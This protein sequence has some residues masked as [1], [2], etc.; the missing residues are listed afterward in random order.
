MPEQTDCPLRTAGVHPLESSDFRREIPKNLSSW[1]QSAVAAQEHFVDSNA[2]AEHLNVKRR[3]ILEMTR[4]GIIPGHPLGI[5]RSRQVW[6][7]KI[8]EV[9]AALV[10]GVR[11]P[12]A[13]PKTDGL[14][15][16]SACHT[17][18]VGSPR[19]QKGKL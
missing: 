15:D 17:M 14:A 6:R 9:E 19:S 5:G 1:L 11:K 18:P 8:S 12:C 16:H 10:S 13:S 2:V 3:Q 7:Y 4:R